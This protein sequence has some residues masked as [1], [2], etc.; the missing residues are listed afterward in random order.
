MKVLCLLIFTFATFFHNSRADHY[1]KNRNNG[2]QYDWYFD[3][4]FNSGFFRYYDNDKNYKPR[5]FYENREDSEGYVDGNGQQKNYADDSDL[6]EN[7]DYRERSN[8]NHGH[9]H[10]HRDNRRDDN[11]YNLES[12]G[13]FSHHHNNDS[14][15]HRPQRYHRHYYHDNY[16]DKY[17]KDVRDFVFNG[18]LKYRPRRYYSSGPNK[19]Y[20]LPYPYYA[21]NY[22]SGSSHAM[23]HGM[24]GDMYYDQINRTNGNY[25]RYGNYIP[26]YLPE[27]N[28]QPQVKNDVTKRTVKDSDGNS[29]SEDNMPKSKVVNGHGPEEEYDEIESPSHQSDQKEQYQP[30]PEDRNH[31]VEKKKRGNRGDE[32][33]SGENEDRRYSRSPGRREEE[34]HKKNKARLMKESKPDGYSKNKNHTSYHDYDSKPRKKKGKGYNKRGKRKRK[35]NQYKGSG[36]NK[37]KY[38]SE[39]EDYHGESEEKD[40]SNNKK[41]NSNR[42]LFTSDDQRKS[43]S[44]R[45]KYDD[46]NGDDEE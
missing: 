24:V 18:G 22:P 2:G 1:R 34:P 26:D 31:H 19:P 7:L 13:E 9:K 32:N 8:K 21:Y 20:K 30:K 46:D 28:H 27:T 17:D 25:D 44:G 6:S 33:D 42:Y 29:N 41:D 37:R 15:D 11:L 36:Y 38:N 23:D 43:G 45:S 5:N 4:E 3:D 12:Y 10:D 39:K 16:F 14:D 35:S 40:D